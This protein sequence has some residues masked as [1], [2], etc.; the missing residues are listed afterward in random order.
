M[1]V[2]K[3]PQVRIDGKRIEYTFDRNKITAVFNGVTDV[4]DLSAVKST[5]NP[6]SIHTTLAF[7]PIER[8]EYVNN[9]LE[10]M[11]TNFIGPDAS[12][13]ERYP[14]FEEV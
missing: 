1:K 11:L 9:D 7:N 3:S 10:V 8:I 6:K 2:Y 5:I 4:F 13:E 12:E 14:H